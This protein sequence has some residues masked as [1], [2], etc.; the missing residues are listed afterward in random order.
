MVYILHFDKPLKHAKHY[1]GF[2][3]NVNKRVEKHRKGTGAR[4]T[5]V[6][7]QV[8]IG[9]VVAAVLPGERDLERKIKNQKHTDRFCPIC[10]AN[11]A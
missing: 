5:Q 4:L 9:F 11:K 1:V 10:A 8:G 2:A 7:K 3:V 6:L